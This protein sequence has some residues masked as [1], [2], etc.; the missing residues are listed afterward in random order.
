M[1]RLYQARDRIEAQLLHDLLVHNGIA[2]TVLGD[3]L[4]GAVGELP[5]DI[6]PTVWVIED[7]DRERAESLLQRHLKQAAA[8]PAPSWICSGCGEFIDGGFELCW[9]C[10]F[11]RDRA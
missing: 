7:R 2:A 8:P 10:G 3:Y 6:Y 9:N 1:H 11:E 4:A 5:A